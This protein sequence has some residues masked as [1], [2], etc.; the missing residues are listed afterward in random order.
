M[1]FKKILAAIG[2]TLMLGATL[3]GAFAASYPS[4]F[5]TQPTVLVVGEN[6]A[7]SDT[8][9]ANL[10]ASGL[11]G[12]TTSVNRTVTL[13][14]G[15]SFK[16]EKSSTKFYFGST[17]NSVYT[18]LDKDELKVGLADGT[19]NDGDIDEDYEQTISL[20]TNALTLF[21]DTKYNDNK[22]TIG[23]L[24][25]DKET[26]LNYT[27]KFDK[28]ID[29][30]KMN[31]T[32][33]PFLGGEYYVVEATPTK[34]TLLDAS[35][36]VIV[37]EG[38]EKTI[39]GKTVSI[40]WADDDE[41]KLVIDGES[42]QKIKE[43]TTKKLR[44]GTYVSV[45]D[46]LYSSKESVKS[47][48]EISIGNGKIILENGKEVIM[49]ED[50]SNKVSN[51]FAYI[52][53]SSSNI[54]SITLEW[55]SKGK[56][57]LTEK[58]SIAMPGFGK[59]GL[60]FGGL[61]YPEESE[62][63]TFET[64]E[65]LYLTTG[66]F[67]KIPILYNKSGGI[68]QGEEGYPL[69]IDLR[70]YTYEEAGYANGTDSPHP[71]WL[72]GISIDNKTNLTAKAL[73]LKE[74]DRFIITAM[75]D[76]LSDIETL[77][78]EVSD[79][80]VD[81]NKI[82]LKLEDKKGNKDIEFV[83]QNVN[84]IK[85]GLS[86]DVGDVTV[87]IAGFNKD[88]DTVYLEFSAGSKQIYADRVVSEKGLVIVLPNAN[89]ATPKV[90]FIE[91]DEKEKVMKGVL[92]SANVKASENDMLYLD[93]DEQQNL[94]LKEESSKNYVGYVKSP[95]AS[96]VKSDKSGDE[97]SFEMEYFGKEVPATVKVVVGASTTTSTE[98]TTEVNSMIVKD[99]EASKMAGKNLIVVGGPCI[100]ALA[101]E[102]LETGKVCGADF[103]TKTGIKA[104]EFLIQS[105]SKDGKVALV[106]A[107]YEA[108]DTTNAAK[109]LKNKGAEVDTSVG[110]K[111]K[112][113]SETSASLFVQ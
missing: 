47:K 98:G 92:F 108:A 15:D 45:I 5:N 96:K 19:Y 51:L 86:K 48:A 56:T 79:I 20:G 31:K 99:N 9:A 82:T 72:N 3:A 32:R 61:A 29:S 30:N 53:N 37:T 52:K 81:N 89:D 16:L 73:A 59:I 23:F 8:D 34:I 12:T 40:E 107:G 112:G 110:K 74:D 67:D 80:E 97:Y 25:N 101:A 63:I 17:L 6:A 58:D 71:P 88:N 103:T 75:D 69:V 113:T 94:T 78:Y 95:L 22:P 104:G 21:K 60:E 54:E 44:D 100:N 13:V 83:D 111:Y 42:T 41:V 55:K 4:P 70:S 14:G 87:K 18:S 39:N 105:V 27:M 106:V 26:I 62:K 68:H 24:F 57:Y 11:G 33:M 35:A 90:T 28:A 109:Y 91:Q 1:K 85:D 46:V 65:T 38:E 77:Y 49:G 102:L 43:G 64:G 66:N 76:D 7:A 2:S 93:V 36:S 10:L 50:T 84:K